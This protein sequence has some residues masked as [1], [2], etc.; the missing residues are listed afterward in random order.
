MDHADREHM[1]KIAVTRGQGRSDGGKDFHGWA[2]L[3]V[4]DAEANG[5]TVEAS[6]IESNP[7]HADICLNLPGEGN[8]RDIQKRHSVD[9]AARA[10]WEDPP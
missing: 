6:P 2:M 4:S 8:R 1:A 5:R 3:T 9:L 7:F 10:S